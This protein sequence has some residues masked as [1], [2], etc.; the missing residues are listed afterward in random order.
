MN[1]LA[2]LSNV[3]MDPLKHVLQ[4]E[5]D[6]ELYFAGYNQW[7]SEL[8][9]PESGLHLFL[10][11]YIFIS[12][13]AEEFQADISELFECVEFYLERH[14]GV[15]VIL[16]NF[17]YPPYSVL[18]YTDRNALDETGLNNRLNDFASTHENVFILD[19]NRLIRFYGYKSLFDDKYWYLGDIKY[20][21]QGFVV[22]SRELKN[23][24][25]SLQNKS[26][27]VLILDLDNTLWGGVVGEEGWQ[28]VNLSVTGV[29]R[30]FVDF[31]RKIKQLQQ[32][33]VLLAVCSKNN[34]KDV[35]EV[36]ENNRSMILSW[37]DFIVHQINWE[38]KSEN[39][40]QI[41]DSLS[42]GLD[43]M[44]FIDDN[45]VEREQVSMAI[46]ELIVPDFPKDITVLNQWFVME[47][48]YP[49]FPKQKITGEDAQKT[50]QYKRNIDREAIRKRLDYNLFIEQL[51]I[52][53]NIFEPSVEGCHRMAQLTQK[54]G[55]FNLTGKK[56]TE[57][58]IRL[59]LEDE[60][61]EIWACEYHDKFGNEGL[62][63]CC[64]VKTEGTKAIIDSFLLSCRVLGR[65]VEFSFLE[66]V[67]NV[68]KQ[69]GIK[70][71]EAHY[72]E[73]PRN[74]PAKY[75]YSE[76]GFKTEDHCKF[77]MTLN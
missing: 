14:K 52:K 11:E 49:F 28:N 29:G 38:R 70:M 40:I 69:N 43:S 66:Y 57:P 5:N 31:Q 44:V 18:T 16:S 17:S 7:Q 26:K 6:S 77:A 46:P 37:D 73:T 21:N 23:V 68:L 61:T 20:S 33:G 67:L 34:E 24:M 32:T 50:L 39:I 48:V 71:V 42:L 51:N 60:N 64:I 8:L 35:R 76:A 27:K 22:L 74:H 45:P 41:A 47:V 59:F 3:N 65:K 72:V 9:N 15:H 19:F 36:F 63:G 4:K 2:V 55:Q 25:A 53:L 75:F 1:K 13:N 12:I 56:Y 30:I 58:E 10:P 54:T 62:I